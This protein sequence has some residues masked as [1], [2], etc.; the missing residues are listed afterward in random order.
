M[1]QTAVP[2]EVYVPVQ[3]IVQKGKQGPSANITDLVPALIEQHS[4]MK[5][6]GRIYHRGIQPGAGLIDLGQANKLNT[7]LLKVDMFNR[8]PL[9]AVGPVGDVS[10]VGCELF[11]DQ[12]QW[13]AKVSL[14]EEPKATGSK[15]KIIEQQMN[16]NPETRYLLLIAVMKVNADREEKAE[17]AI[18]KYDSAGQDSSNDSSDDTFVAFIQDILS[19]SHNIMMP[20]NNMVEVQKRYAFLQDAVHRLDNLNE[21]LW[22]ARKGGYIVPQSYGLQG[23]SLDLGQKEVYQGGF[24]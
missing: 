10:M 11:W 24:Q 23:K 22:K 3:N 13:N 4:P 12:G 7:T 19:M 9:K 8:Y 17:Q 14:P 21:G 1:D 5:K 6:G 18:I 2:L 15:A 20:G 16:S